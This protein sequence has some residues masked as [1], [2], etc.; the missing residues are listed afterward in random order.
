MQTAKQPVKLFIDHASQ[1]SRAIVVF[2]RVA[3]IPHEIV[4]TRISKMDHLKPEFAKINPNKKVPAIV[5]DG[6]NLAESHAIMRYL[7]RTFNVAEQWYPRQD[8]KRTAKIDEYLDYHHT[9]TRRFSNLLFWS[10]LGPAMGL[11][12]PKTFDKEEATK[13]VE[14][15]LKFLNNNY[16]GSTPY[17]G[18]FRLIQLVISRASPIYQPMKN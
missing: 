7:A 1:P 3:N 5:H 13:E 10:A 2:C 14:R 18:I 16:L 4:D 8:L 17:I 12:P 15:A 11:Q 6:L 9:G